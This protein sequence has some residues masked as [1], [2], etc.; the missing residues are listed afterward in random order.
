MENSDSEMA[1]QPQERKQSISFEEKGGG[2]SPEVDQVSQVG[3]AYEFSVAQAIP[4]TAGRIQ[5]YTLRNGK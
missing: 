1:K 2:E 5:H 3:S 4:F